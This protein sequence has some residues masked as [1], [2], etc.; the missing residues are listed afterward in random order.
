MVINQKFMIKQNFLVAIVVCAIFTMFTTPTTSAITFMA[1]KEISSSEAILDDA[2]AAGG[3]V[4]ID[5]D[6]EGD[7]F[8]AGGSLTINGDIT[9]DLVVAGGQV[10][11]N[12]NVSDDVRAAGGSVFINGNIGDDLITTGGQMNLSSG[13]LVGG[14]IILGSGFANILG[15]VNEDIKGGGGKIVLGGTVYGSVEVE[16][17]DSIVLTDNAKIN[18]NLIYS[19]L[20]KAELNEEQ[21]EGFIE[22]NELIKVENA[23]IGQNIEDFFS[24][25][26]VF[27]QI[28]QYISIMILAFVLIMLIPKALIDTANI[29]KS[30][31]WRSLGLGFVISLCSIAAV[32]IL[33]ITLVGLPL[34]LILLAIFIITMYL[35]KIYAGIFIGMLIANPKKMTKLK[36]FGIA[37]LGIFIIEVVELVPFIGWLITLLTVILGFGALWTHKKELYDKLNMNKI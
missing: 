10:T 11:I 9:G 26:H 17:Q 24:K 23:D 8:V 7:L 13:S 15:T 19:G 27:L 6:V 36:L 20:R 18:G 12:G 2:Y 1:D 37:A 33:S 30:H 21:V 22:Y 32:I 5:S 34:A 31:P 16:V 3:L 14:S 4:T 25:L 29:A 35:A 28:F